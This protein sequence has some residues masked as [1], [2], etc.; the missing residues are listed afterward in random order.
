[1][2]V[3]AFSFAFCLYLSHLSNYLFNRSIYLHN[4]LSVYPPTSLSLYLSL[5]VSLSIA[6]SQYL[7]FYLSTY[8]I[9]PPYT[10]FLS[11]FSLSLRSSHCLRAAR[12]CIHVLEGHTGEISSTQFNYMG[13]VCVTGSIDGTVKL[14]NVVSGKCVSTVK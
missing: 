10:F 13:D 6:L 11:L 1:M 2:C 14:W 8:P 9:H 5:Y 7:S 3:L 4:Y 12:R